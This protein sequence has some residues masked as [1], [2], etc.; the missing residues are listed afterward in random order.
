MA[1]HH[2]GIPQ[3]R[4]RL[5]MVALRD[6]IVVGESFRFPAGDASRTPS[7]S[8]FLKKRLAKQYVNTIRCGGR[9]SKD[10]HAWDMVPRTNG[11]WYQLSV[12]DCQRLMGFPSAYKMPVPRT[13]QF[14]LLGN[15]I[16]LEP[17]RSLMREC[18]RVIHEA[19]EKQT[20]HKR[21]KV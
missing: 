17:A 10:K 12:A 9:G 21:V 3:K 15:A 20:D 5:Y 11:K 4:E 8:K 1:T 19:Y 6:D 2:Y 16:S 18:K 7:A 13:H 14:R